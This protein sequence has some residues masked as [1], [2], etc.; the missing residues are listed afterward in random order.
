MLKSFYEILDTR[1]IEHT[2]VKFAG[3]LPFRF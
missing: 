3:L 2:V 1:T